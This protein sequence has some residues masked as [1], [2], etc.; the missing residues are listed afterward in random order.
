MKKI[1]RDVDEKKGIVQVTIADE[2]W[3]LKTSK[4]SEGL[5][6][7]QEVPSVTWIAGCYPK[8]IGYFKWLAEKGWDEA[9]ALKVA[10]GDKGTKVHMAIEN[11]FRG[12][13]VRID[14]KFINKSTEK[15][16]ELTLDEC[17]AIISFLDFK[18]EM[19]EECI[20]ETIAYE[21]TIFSESMN[22]AGTIDWIVRITNRETKESDIWI[23]DFK[24]SQ[25]IFEAHK[26]QVN[27]YRK[28]IENGENA[29]MFN[30]KQIDASNIKMGVLQVG[31]R[32]NKAGYKWNVIE[33]DEEGVDIARRLWKKEHGEEKA[34]KKD[35]PIVLSVALKAED[36]LFPDEL[37]AKKAPKKVKNHQNEE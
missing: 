27:L 20:L 31:Y 23:I 34:S 6:Y 25:N 5:P 29:I 37:K 8:G 33:R 28:T 13:E 11:T 15:E 24:T 4:N 30:G 32:K 2:R 22:Y 36:V 26:I 35:Y 7:I 9:E 19:E 12:E 14:S 16:E 10:A 3:Y 17:D 18:K 1:I 21:T